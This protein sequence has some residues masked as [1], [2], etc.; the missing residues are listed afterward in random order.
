MSLGNP[1]FTLSVCFHWPDCVSLPCLVIS[2]SLLLHYSSCMARLS[3]W[4]PSAC[5]GWMRGE[6]SITVIATVSCLT[7]LYQENDQ[8]YEKRAFAVSSLIHLKLDVSIVLQLWDTVCLYS[9]SG[10]A[11][12]RVGGVGG[13]KYCTL[14]Q[15]AVANSDALM[16]SPSS[17]SPIPPTKLE[18][19]VV[20]NQATQCSCTR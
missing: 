5:D 6:Y 20:R 15:L 19:T 7:R 10:Q 8:R 12:A 13:W 4:S 17:P 1:Q 9:A 2:A 11:K 14:W 3:P 18:Y 16:N